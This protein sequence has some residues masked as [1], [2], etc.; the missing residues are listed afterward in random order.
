[1]NLFILFILTLLQ[2]PLQRQNLGLVQ[3]G[4]TTCVTDADCPPSWNK[5]AI[6]CSIPFV[7]TTSSSPATSANNTTTL[8]TNP[9][10]NSEFKPSCIPYRP[11]GTPCQ[12]RLDCLAHAQVELP[13][14]QCIDEKCSDIG[15]TTGNYNRTKLGEDRTPLWYIILGCALILLIVGL[16]VFIVFYKRKFKNIK[17][18]KRDSMD[19]GVEVSEAKKA[20]GSGKCRGLSSLDPE[21]TLVRLTNGEEEDEGTLRGAYRTKNRGLVGEDDEDEDGKCCSRRRSGQIRYEG[22]EGKEAKEKVVEEEEEEDNEETL[23]RNGKDYDHH[24]HHEEAEDAFN[25]GTLAREEELDMSA[26]SNRRFIEINVDTLQRQGSRQSQRVIRFKNDEIS[27]NPYSLGRSGNGGGIGKNS[28]EVGEIIYR[29]S[30]DPAQIDGHPTY[31]SSTTSSTT[32]PEDFH[33][34]ISS[35]PLP[36]TTRL[37]KQVVKKESESTLCNAITTSTSTMELTMEPGYNTMNPETHPMNPTSFTAL[38]P[39]HVDR[40]EAEMEITSIPITTTKISSST[41]RQPLFHSSRITKSSSLSKEIKVNDSFTTAATTTTTTSSSPSYYTATSSFDDLTYSTTSQNNSASAPAPAPVP[42]MINQRGDSRFH[43]STTTTTK[44]AHTH[45]NLKT[46]SSNGHL[47]IQRN[48][49][50]NSN[51]NIS[52]NINANSNNQTKASY[53]IPVTSIQYTSRNSMNSNNNNNP[54]SSNHRNDSLGVVVHSKKSQII[55]ENNANVKKSTNPFK[56]LNDVN[57]NINQASAMTSSSS[58]AA[59]LNSRNNRQSNVAVP[60]TPSSG[61]GGGGVGYNNSARVYKPMSFVP[62]PPSQPSQTMTI[63]PSHIHGYS[64]YKPL[65]LSQFQLQQQQYQ[66]QQQQQQQQHLQLQQQQQQQ[67]LQLQQQLQRQ[68]KQQPQHRSYPVQQRQ[69]QTNAFST[70]SYGMVTSTARPMNGN[71]STPYT[72]SN[73]T[74]HLP[75]N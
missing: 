3:A 34:T 23:A 50:T 15:K 22:K 18:W 4:P 31:Y 60:V 43:D 35:P 48:T 8:P 14:I 56:N 74:N 63:T 41:P 16:G 37:S 39:D 24:H 30:L 13:N 42:V 49:N 6:F 64:P 36:P 1:M 66:L 33:N 55:G 11:I 7:D 9:N 65:Q 51:T 27:H 54:S 52:A 29:N 62:N 45:T 10:V 2:Q 59:A 20:N 72:N 19:S 5:D 25:D 40:D 12:T 47:N 67:Q 58:Y 53:S 26:A 38:S 57:V 75:M 28:D 68:Q 73:P 32:N 70:N 69:L 44:N 71:S 21:K 46:K 17:K 61:G